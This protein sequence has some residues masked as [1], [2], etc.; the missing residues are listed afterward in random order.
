M[1]TV[2]IPSL[3]K[4]LKYAYKIL[5]SGSVTIKGK[6]ST[7]SCDGPEVFYSF[8]WIAAP[9]DKEGKVYGTEKTLNNQSASLYVKSNSLNY[10]LYMVQFY[11]TRNSTDIETRVDYGIIEIT[12]TPLVAHI[13]GGNVVTRGFTHPIILD[14][15]KS[16]D[17]DVELYKRDGIVFTW[18]CRKVGESWPLN[19]LNALPIISLSLGGDS[20][21]F[22]TG[23]GKLPL[24]VTPEKITIASGLLAVQKSYQFVVLLSKD[25][26]TISASQIVKLVPGDPPDTKLRL[27]N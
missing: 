25:D 2:S 6:V 22:G 19:D 21:C 1:P 23:I 16:Y 7:V 5:R 9:I 11:V 12:P 14:A 3:Q 20:G 15:S 26:R 17:P 8:K 13:A 18:L 10:G 4:T 24:Q 27:A